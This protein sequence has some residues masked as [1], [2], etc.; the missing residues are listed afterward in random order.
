MEKFLTENQ[1]PTIQ[2]II[3]QNLSQGSNIKTDSN[4][5]S[6]SNTST[7]LD[8]NKSSTLSTLLENFENLNGIKKLAV[9]L[10]FLKITLL[11][12]LL[13]IVFVFYGDYLL[14]KYN[15]EN[16]FP[17]LG[18]IIQ[19]RKKYTRYYLVLSSIIIITVIFTEIVLCI[20]I[21]SL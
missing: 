8:I 3:N 1:T 9:S 12:S 4:L 17:K 18:K 14:T 16:R 2:D 15:I 19:L 6:E 13:S 10:L 7:E 11:S 21:L 5:S 20:S